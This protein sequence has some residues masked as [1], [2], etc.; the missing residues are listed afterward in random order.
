LLLLANLASI[1]PDAFTSAAAH[2]RMQTSAHLIRQYTCLA[3]LGRSNPLGPLVRRSIH[4][5]L[6]MEISRQSE[7]CLKRWRQFASENNLAIT[8]ID[9]WSLQVGANGIATHLIRGEIAQAK[10]L[11]ERI[12]NDEALDETAPL[13]GIAPNST[14][15]AAIAAAQAA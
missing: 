6:M 1:T 9:T 2:I 11:E 15:S 12:L 8:E 10:R 14:Q 7:L 13:S 5:P 4:R 3:L